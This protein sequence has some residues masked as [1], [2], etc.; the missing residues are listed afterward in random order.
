[1]S[2]LL[3]LRIRGY[4][5]DLDSDESRWSDTHLR[6]F[7]QRSACTITSLHV[8]RLTITDDQM[9]SLLQMIS[10]LES[11]YIEELREDHE[12]L[13]NLIITATFLDRFAVN[14][15]L[16]S[17]FSV[18]LV[19]RLTDLKLVVHAEDIQA[20]RVLNAITSRWLPEPTHAAEIGVECLRSVAIV[21]ML[22][23]ADQQG[24]CLDALLGLRDA[25]MRLAITYGD[26]DELYPDE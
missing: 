19:P 25:G 12:T 4:P 23:D 3:S 26:V 14:P 1:M 5:F 2:G 15:C 18:P 6:C 10:T 9:L 21:V 24:G 22:D 7:L 11:L 20:D 17:L 8:E 16:D 13:V